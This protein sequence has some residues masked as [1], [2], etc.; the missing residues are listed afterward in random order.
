MTKKETI[1]IMAMLGAF[2]GAGKSNPE[3][4]AEGWYL[5][6]KSYDFETA[7]KAVLTF[8]KNDTRDYATFPAVGKIVQSIEE[9]MRKDH[10]PIKEIVRAVSYGYGYDQLSDVAKDN[11][12]EDHYNEWLDMD[13]EEFANNA[14]I[15]SEQLR[16]G[17]RGRLLEGKDA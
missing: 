4:M 6:L 5:I 8:A 1:Q 2:Y 10:A 9:E 17:T 3:I 7:R 14:K 12:S 13:A 16:N 15:L 11:I